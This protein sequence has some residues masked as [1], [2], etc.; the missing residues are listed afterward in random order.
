M[1]F[2]A[3]RLSSST[4]SPDS[5]FLYRDNSINKF[6]S[7]AAG[8]TGVAATVID[9]DR[10]DE[11]I[12]EG[13]NAEGYDVIEKQLYN[14]KN[15]FAKT[16][17]LYVYQILPDGCH[18][19]FDLAN[20]DEAGSDPGSIVEFDPSFEPMLPTL[21][22][23]GDID[24]IIS[25]D[26]Y[27]W[28]L[29]VYKSIKNSAGKTVAYVAADISMEEIVLDESKF[30]IKMLSL[31]FGLSIIIMSV[32]IELVKRGIV[33]PVNKMTR[34]AMKFAGT[35]SIIGAS[36]DIRDANLNSL[37]ACVSRI[38]SLAIHTFD[39]IGHLYESLQSMAGD[40]FNF[41]QQVQA[42][43]RRI[44]NMQEITINEFAEMVESRDKSTG[45]HI[46]KTAAYVEAIALQLAHEGKFRDILT[47]EYIHKLKRSAPLHDIG[48]IAVSDLILNKPGKLTD[49][50]YKIMQT[51][52]TAGYEI[53]K[54][55]EEQAGDTM[56]EGYLK[57]SIEM[58][59]Y[60]HEKWDGT[61]YP[62]HMKGE[63][64]PLSARIMA[65]ADVF[66][67]LVAERVY[68]KPF[69]YEKAMAI[70]TEGA[71]KHFDPVVVEAFKHISEKLYNE[72]TR[73]E[74]TPQDSLV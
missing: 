53:L 74:Q 72:R 41:I 8:V 32:V 38:D 55:M 60:H 31:F 46:K 62:N 39:E 40:T 64:I 12:R 52:T 50:E 11:F 51:H 47:P 22:A 25:D 20:G 27:G 36:D 49:E 61:G 56:D 59:Y 4:S 37:K 69:T 58:A 70:I 66:D 10:I 5:F 30:F 23:G 45:N 73:L 14:I 48:K 28:L 3:S 16:T 35:A 18:V 57:E 43:S 42:Q 17:Y 68:K 29:T 9:G 6:T 2:F 24:P 19:V 71:G 44:M 54:N 13:H 26:Q 65:V 21:L 7:I 1:C 33:I 34:S 67:A 63:E 15:S